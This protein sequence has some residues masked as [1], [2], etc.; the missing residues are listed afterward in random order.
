VECW[1]GL[2]RLLP[3]AGGWLLTVAAAVSVGVGVLPV[4]FIL[5]MGN[6]MGA[7]SLAAGSVSA[8]LATAATALLVAV[9]AFAVQQVLA[10]VQA[11]VAVV[12]ARRIDG[13]CAGE[14]MTAAM[15]APLAAVEE[16][17]AVETASDATYGFLQN[18]HTPGL[19]AAALFPLLSR[20]LQLGAALV[21]VGVELSWPL[22]ALVGAAALA[23]RRNQRISLTRFGASWWSLAAP[24][25]RFRYLWSLGIESEST[26]EV[27]SLG[28]S[29]W[30]EDRHGRE[31]RDYLRGLWVLRR[32]IYFRPFLG[33]S[34]VVLVTAVLAFAS[35]ARSPEFR[36][37]VLG[38]AV[39][40]Q[41]LLVPL[42]FGSNFPECDVPTEFGLLAHRAIQRYRRL[43]GRETPPVR[44]SAG[45]AGA[46]AVPPAV[47]FDGVHF[48]YPGS[49]RQVLGGLD[50]VLPAGR[51]T[52]IVG[53]NGAGKTTLVK[54]LC[55]LYQP[56]SGRIS[57]DGVELGAMDQADWRRRIAVILQ[58]FIRY[59]LSVRDNVALGGLGRDAS[60]GAS[61]G[62]GDAIL[63]AL[64]QANAR[65]MLADLPS[66]LD[67]VLSPRYRGGVDLSGGQWQR[68][69]LARALHAVQCGAT[70]LVL[71]EPTAQLDVRS[72]VAF[73]DRFFELTAGLTSIVISHRFSTVRRADRIVVLS[74][75]HITEAGTHTELLAANGPYATM[76]RLQASKFGGPPVPAGESV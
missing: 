60:R 23:V 47:S 36:E 18:R 30:L 75:G 45:G 52:A 50:L 40:I 3:R 7:L 39:A 65:D 15:T 59:E 10:P 48:G 6:V 8:A 17:A 16:T 12:V 29:D 41:A 55:G 25:R 73:F 9:V 11:A 5:A 35:I 53:L 76:F 20:Y 14:F 72:E 4:T 38:L 63:R 46:P 32:S 44:A 61:G 24:R 2:A 1:L 49:G 62:A 28:L 42:T 22:A 74:D 54:L 31:S 33:Y 67:T 71:D 57:V 56:D 51:S 21:V 27:R 64:A 68:V 34:V 43:V 69:A 19:G 37:N 58:N 26:K 70:V 66:G 13:V